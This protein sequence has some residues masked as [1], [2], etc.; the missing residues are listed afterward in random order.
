MEV[1]FPD[2][3]LYDGLYIF[4]GPMLYDTTC[5]YRILKF[6]TWNFKVGKSQQMSLLMNSLYNSELGN[7]M[8]LG[9]FES[10]LI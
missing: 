7:F 8:F 1:F 5:T 10:A 4:Y 6:P 3:P 9:F 2:E